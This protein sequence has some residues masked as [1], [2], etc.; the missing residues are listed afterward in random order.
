M[1]LLEEEHSRYRNCLSKSPKL[2]ACLER[3]VWRTR[4]QI[5]T[6]H[7]GVVGDEVREATEHLIKGL[8]DHCKA[9]GLYSE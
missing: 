1:W 8:V 2:G 4:R 9:F 7:R 5:R 6:N 3:S